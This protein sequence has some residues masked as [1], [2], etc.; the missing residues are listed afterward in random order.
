MKKLMFLSVALF[1]CVTVFAQKNLDKLPEAKRNEIL[2]K[3]ARKVIEKYG[4]D[5]DRGLPPIVKEREV[6]FV[7]D[8]YRV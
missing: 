3:T 6:A 2:I 5:F 7:K 1:I 8:R 4:S